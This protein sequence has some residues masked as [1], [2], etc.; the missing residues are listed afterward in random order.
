M[1]TTKRALAGAGVGALLLLGAG[2]GDEGDELSEE[3]FL[4]Q[5][6]EICAQGNEELDAAFEEAFPDDDAEPTPQQVAALFL[7][8]LIPNVQAQIDD[9]EGLEGPDSLEEDLDAVLEDAEAALDDLEQ[10]ANDD[11]ES[12]F[13]G[14]DPFADINPRLEELGLTTCAEGD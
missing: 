13:T 2:C 14:G 4:A 9:L 10:Q 12:L 6:N 1:G 3:E 11:P 5:G 8:E 7:D